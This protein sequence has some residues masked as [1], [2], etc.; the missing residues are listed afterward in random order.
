NITPSKT[1]DNTNSHNK[2]G[3]SDGVYDKNFEVA[4]DKYK[5][6]MNQDHLYAE[7]PITTSDNVSETAE[8]ETWISQPTQLDVE[9]YNMSTTKMR[10]VA[11]KS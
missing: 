9:D 3:S 7:E 11:K 6:T 5:V 8:S 10:K 4:C 1:G 2:N